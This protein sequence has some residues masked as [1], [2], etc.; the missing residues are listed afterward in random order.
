MSVL[1]FIRLAPAG[2][3]VPRLGHVYYATMGAG[4]VIALL[5]ISVTLPLLNRMTSPD[6]ARFE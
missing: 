1:T 5:V 6:N 3:A 2:T 4:L